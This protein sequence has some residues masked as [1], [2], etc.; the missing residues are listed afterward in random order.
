MSTQ[1]FQPH[2]SSALPEATP[3]KSS[4]TNASLVEALIAQSD[5]RGLA[6]SQK[7]HKQVGGNLVACIALSEMIRQELSHCQDHSSISRL[8]GQLETT[9]RESIQDVRAI[10]EQQYPPI[11]KA[12][13]LKAALQDLVDSMVAEFSGAVVLKIEIDDFPM[14]AYR[15]LNLY[16][17]FEELLKHCM[18]DPQAERIE[19]RLRGDNRH[20]R[21]LV[22][23]EGDPAHWDENH[24]HPR[25]III[26]SRCRLLGSHF[27]A[28]CSGTTRS[29]R[30]G[31][32]FDPLVE[33]P[34]IVGETL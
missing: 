19:I 23:Y 27:E 32:E 7:L 4:F 33:V 21:L 2:D 16:H 24:Y 25:L 12:F 18:D 34:S 26:H 5:R 6:L 28:E 1:S 17:L 13:G 10:C 9:L 11:L 8:A 15:A 14:L 22:A 30:F 3:L 20:V 31:F 29:L